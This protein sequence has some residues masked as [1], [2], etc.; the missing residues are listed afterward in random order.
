MVTALFVAVLLSPSA[1]LATSPTSPDS[2]VT[3]DI[4]FCP[5]GKAFEDASCSPIRDKMNTAIQDAKDAAANNISGTIYLDYGQ[6]S[7]TSNV[8]GGGV[9][10]IE[11]FDYGTSLTIQGGVN[12]GTTTFTNGFWAD[13][14]KGLNI[15]LSDVTITSPNNG[16]YGQYNTGDIIF[17]NVHVDSNDLLGIYIVEHN[18]NLTILQGSANSNIN[19]KVYLYNISG[20]LTIS[21]FTALSSTNG[22]GMLIYGIGGKNGVNMQSV[23]ASGNYDSNISIQ[24]ITQNAK[25]S[26]VTA[27]G[28]LNN[29]GIDITGVLGKGG[30]TLTDVTADSNAGRNIGIFGTNTGDVTATN[31]NANYSTNGEGLLISDVYGK[32]GVTINSGNISNNN[33]GNLTVT[34]ITSNV[35]ISNTTTNQSSSGHGIEI[36]NISGSKGATLTNIIADSNKYINIHLDYLLGDANL[37]GIEAKEGESY[38]VLITNILGKKGVTLKDAN[39]SENSYNNF[40]IQTITGNVTLTDVT[41]NESKTSNGIFLG[42]I[43]GSKGITLTNVTA[44]GNSSNNIEAS[45]ITGNA[46]LNNVTNENSLSGYGLKL[47]NIKGSKGITLTGIIANYNFFGNV[48]LE[49]IAGNATL[50]TISANGSL[51]NTGIEIKNVQGSKGLSIKDT[52]ANLNSTINIDLANI[53]G[54]VSVTNTEANQSVNDSG[55][56][57]DTISGSKGVTLSNVKA[58]ENNINGVL[59]Q[60]ITGGVKLSGVEA[61]SNANQYGVFIDAVAGKTGVVLS[62]VTAN[63]NRHQNINISNVTYDANIS[64]VQANTSLTSYGLSIYNIQGSK[65][66]SLKTVTAENNQISNIFI[67]TITGNVDVKTVVANG[68]K[69]FKGIYIENVQGT[70]GVSING[71]NASSNFLQNL[72]ITTINSGVSLT[73]I[74]ANTS[75]S[76]DGIKVE[77]INGSK[78]VSMKTVTASGNTSHNIYITNIDPGNVT[79][80]GVTADSSVAGNGLRLESVF[81]TVTAVTSQFN[82]NNQQGI[83]ADSIKGLIALKSIKANNNGSGGA[84][85][86]FF[87]SENNQ[88]VCSSEFNNNGAYGIDTYADGYSITLSAVTFS[89]NTSGD[90]SSTGTIVR[91]DSAK[92]SVI[93]VPAP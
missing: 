56:D 65:G 62:G 42:G 25:L 92:C 72:Q 53:T 82:A 90:F 89:G 14:N 46:T 23:T 36:T 9:I 44:S 20:N 67:S 51:K 52:F 63:G 32:K 27:N 66:V 18:G 16:F 6:Y 8:F 55:L 57:I 83:Y 64:N 40:F 58:N 31:T 48:Y 68:S 3:G 78:G 80:T 87:I 76:G 15:T 34:S 74:Q 10:G 7:N 13:G 41:A 77:A 5:Q 28:S 73:G 33:S 35:S 24:S 19:H 11:G 79:M 22:Y 12:G 60:F 39:A 61:I 70:K 45:V 4:Q 93:P 84:S 47:S 54:N 71:L 30:V 37:T 29:V 26:Q 38:G 91:N 69:T 17:N 75:T 21:D 2:F 81:G 88:L 49:D 85:G 1:V 86:S 43:E 50:S 59:A